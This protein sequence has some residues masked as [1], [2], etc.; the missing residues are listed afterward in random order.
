MR[1]CGRFADHCRFLR[2]YRW[3][4]VWRVRYFPTNTSYRKLTEF[5]FYLA[6]F[7][8]W[9]RKP[10]RKLL[11]SETS[12]VLSGSSHLYLQDRMQPDFNRTWRR[13]HDLHTIMIRPKGRIW[14]SYWG[15]ERRDGK[16][17]MGEHEVEN[18]NLPYGPTGSW[19]RFLSIPAS[20]FN[21]NI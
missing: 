12:W 6:I 5:P 4:R 9:S 14:V 16:S 1:C 7:G 2:C 18:N 11:L 3:C 20:S 13:T 15:T 17:R 19:P 21:L 8:C 10:S